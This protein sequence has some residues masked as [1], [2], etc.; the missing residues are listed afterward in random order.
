MTCTR[1]VHNSVLGTHPVWSSAGASAP[2][3]TQPASSGADGS[4]G[5]ERG[6]IEERASRFR[7]SSMKFR[8]TSVLDG[9]HGRV[10]MLSQGR[11]ATHSLWE[12]LIAEYYQMDTKWTLESASDIPDTEHSSLERL[13]LASPGCSSQTHSVN[14]CRPGFS[15]PLLW[16][17]SI[18]YRGKWRNTECFVT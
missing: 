4:V 17:T 16:D 15:V 12:A 8:S 5:R 10:A 2:S 7:N 1:P 18:L 13:H 11:P 14:L 6:C 3:Q 9:V